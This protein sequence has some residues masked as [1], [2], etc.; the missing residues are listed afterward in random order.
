MGL[1]LAYLATFVVLLQLGI[2]IDLLSIIGLIL[3][4]GIL[5]DDAIIITE[6]YNELLGQGFSPKDAAYK[7][8]QDMVVPVTGGILTTVV[9]FSPNT[10]CRMVHA[11]LSLGCT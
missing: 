9:A 5:V 2:K 7:A 3:V 4:V 8:V 11:L 1:P 10:V 6:R